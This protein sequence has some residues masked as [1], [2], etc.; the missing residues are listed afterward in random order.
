MAVSVHGARVTSRL[1][2]RRSSQLLGGYAN[3]TP[4]ESLSTGRMEELI[5]EIGP[6]IKGEVTEGGRRT[7]LRHAPTSG[8]IRLDADTGVTFIATGPFYG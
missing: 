6:D 8:R 4:T 1:R 5:K 2:S 7:G 3:P